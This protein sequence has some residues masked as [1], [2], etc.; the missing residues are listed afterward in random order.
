MGSVKGGLSKTKK[1]REKYKDKINE[2]NAEI[3]VIKKY[4]HRIYI[5]EEGKKNNTT[6]NRPRL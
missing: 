5:I 4:N 6:T 3:D 2:L 1:N